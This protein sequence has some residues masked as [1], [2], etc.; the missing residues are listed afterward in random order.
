MSKLTEEERQALDAAHAIIVSHTPHGASWLIGFSHT[1]VN[2]GPAYFDS[3]RTQHMLW[4]EGTLAGVIERGIGMESTVDTRGELLKKARI[5][6]LKD[7]LERLE[8][9]A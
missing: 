8:A 6:V 1:G 9:S 4:G 3:L 7:E 5:A 2:A